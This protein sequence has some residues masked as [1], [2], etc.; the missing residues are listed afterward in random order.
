MKKAKDRKRNQAEWDGYI[1]S[2]GERI[3][4]NKD[5]MI[6]NMRRQ[7][8]V[9]KKLKAAYEESIDTQEKMLMLKAKDKQAMKEKI[10]RFNAELIERLGRYDSSENQ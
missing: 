5:Q 6:Q 4:R 2:I 7:I 1:S 10:D 3:D 8:E 9:M